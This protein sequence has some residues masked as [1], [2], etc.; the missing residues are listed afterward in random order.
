MKINRCI[1]K[2]QIY[3]ALSFLLGIVWVTILARGK[4]PENTLMDQALSRALLEAGWNKKELLVQCILS[5]GLIFGIILI[6]A[7]T[8]MRKGMQW[9]VVVWIGFGFGVM[10]KLFYLW[11][12]IKGVGLCITALI[13]HFIFYW[14]A[15][16]LICWE[17]DRHRMYAKQNIPPILL[18]LVV[19]IMGI[20][21]ESYVN[22]NLIHT[23]IKIFF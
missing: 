6:L 16:G 3:F 13:P 22:P 11:Y 2:Q 4:I 14:M 8:P 20:I 18:A 10:F 19:V 21:L 1:T 23:Y 5:R 9:G 12:G 17:A 15:Y 7:H